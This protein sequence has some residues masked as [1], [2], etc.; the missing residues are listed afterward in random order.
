VQWSFGVDQTRVTLF[1]F[2]T[3]KLMSASSPPPIS[4]DVQ[5][6]SLIEYPC[7]FPV[8][9]MGARVDGFA[10]AMCHVAQQFD[11][12]FNPATL[13]M[14]ASKAGNYLSV[15]LTIRATSREQLDNLY[16]A[17]TGHPMVKVAL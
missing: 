12:S 14:R 9:V 10:E 2:S 1:G 17:L 8:K 11:P 15:T 16:L 4:T 5:R 13:E 7:D 3:S 6:D